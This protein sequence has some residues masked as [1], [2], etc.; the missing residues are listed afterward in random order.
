MLAVREPSNVEHE[1]AVQGLPVADAAD[2][3]RAEAGLGR[4]D[5][6]AP[7]DI[8]KVGVRRTH[9][10]KSKV[11]KMWMEPLNPSGTANGNHVCL[12]NM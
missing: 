4:G 8:V 11:P 5:Q 12:S 6:G 1:R 9:E 7:S 3:F 10:T 2:G